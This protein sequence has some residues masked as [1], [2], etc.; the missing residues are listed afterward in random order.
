MKKTFFPFIAFLCVSLFAFSFFTGCTKAKDYVDVD[1]DEF[2]QLISTGHVAVLDVR[3]LAEYEKGHIEG[4]LLVNLRDSDF[5]QRV[6]D[7]IE[8]ACTVAVYC[9][10]GIRSASAAEKL[11]AKGYSVVNL[12]GG[13]NAY[14]AMQPVP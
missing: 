2:A 14:T 9:Q 3:T 13:Y 7:R 12:K 8:K 6:T 5:V 11:A 10:S 4:A 1:A